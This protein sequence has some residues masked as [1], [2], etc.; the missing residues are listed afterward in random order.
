[1]PVYPAAG[2][3]ELSDIHVQHY[4]YCKADNKGDPRNT[5]TDG[6]HLIKP[7]P[8]REV[9]CHGNVEGKQENNHNR[10]KQGEHEGRIRVGGK[11]ERE[12]AFSTAQPVLER[13]LGK[14][15][16]KR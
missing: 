7:P 13:C 6:G 8:E 4:P 15:P 14:A 10:T 5:E 11:E 1:M 9:L 12:N 16:V 3:S 2:R